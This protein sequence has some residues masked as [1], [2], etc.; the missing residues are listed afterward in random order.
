MRLWAA[1]WEWLLLS[2]I[3]PFIWFSL[4]CTGGAKGP[5]YSHFAVDSDWQHHW[6]LAA[7][8][9]YHFHTMEGMFML[10]LPSH[11][12]WEMNV[13]RECI[14]LF[15]TSCQLGFFT[16]KQRGEDENHEDWAKFLQ[17]RWQQSF[18]MTTTRCRVSPGLQSNSQNPSIL[19]FPQ[20]FFF[21]SRESVRLKER[22]E[23]RFIRKE[24][25]IV[26][27]HCCV[28]FPKGWSSV[29]YAKWDKK[30][31]IEAPFLSIRRIQP[32]LTLA[33]T[34]FRLISL[35]QEAS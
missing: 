21:I 15:L 4:D 1:E 31:S 16:R 25:G 17:P 9:P 14:N 26:V 10:Q 22:C 5:S 8:G 33:A 29:S 13:Y 28:S 11:F 12:F 23:G 7:S 24:K 32:A 3:P 34:Y 30:G 35:S 18:A 2:L 19:C 6:R 20:C 27:Q